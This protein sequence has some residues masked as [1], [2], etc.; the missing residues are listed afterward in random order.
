[1][2][3][4]RPFEPANPITLRKTGHG[5]AVMD[6]ERPIGWVNRLVSGVAGAIIRWQTIISTGPDR[7]D[8][9]ALGIARTRR[10]AIRSV[11]RNAH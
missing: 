1:M 8:Y 10:D 9:K 2:T 6:G 11:L 7:W 3:H 5:Y 4:F